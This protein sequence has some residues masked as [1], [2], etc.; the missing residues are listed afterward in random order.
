MVHHKVCPLCSSEKI[1][2]HLLCT[3]HF[4]TKEDFEIYKCSSCSFEFTQDYPVEKEIGKYYESA[5]YISH[6][7][8]SKGLYNKIYR[9]VRDVMLRRKK[10]MIQNATGLQKGTLIDIGSGTGHFGNIMKKEGWQVTGIEINEKARD[11]SSSHF[12][13]EVK[14]PAQI[15]DLET[16]S[17]D[18][19]TLWHVLEH[20]HDPFKLSGEIMRLLKPG[21]LCLIALPNCSS[22]DSKYYRQFWAAYDVPRHLWHFNPSVFTLFAERAGFKLEKI[23]TLPLDVFY[24]SLLSEKYKGARIP[25]ITGIARAKFFAL[26]ALFNKRRSS[27]IIYILRK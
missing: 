22:F 19:I 4:I 8:T 25:F 27:S 3:D 14:S 10:R 1:S 2:F 15:S 9:L 16:N 26:K 20:Y 7:D 13:L 24:I 21:G 6:S 11:F 5:D 18:C 12:G 23:M 17:F